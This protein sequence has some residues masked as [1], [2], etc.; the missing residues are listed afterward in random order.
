[1]SKESKLEITEIESITTKKRRTTNNKEIISNP[2]KNF[3]L[4]DDYPNTEL[5]EKVSTIDYMFNT[6]SKKKKKWVNQ[7]HFISKIPR[8]QKDYCMSF[9]KYDGWNSCI[10]ILKS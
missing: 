4:K 7:D 5:V 6:S 8:P 2:M 10:P 1:M 3:D 9:C